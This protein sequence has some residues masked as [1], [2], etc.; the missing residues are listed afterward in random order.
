MLL[1]RGRLA[2]VSARRRRIL[3][4]F[5]A[6]AGV[7]LVHLAIASPMVTL[8]AGGLVMAFTYIKLGLDEFL[9]APLRLNPLSFY[10]FWL[11]VQA[12]L[13]ASYAGYCIFS[14]ETL[15]LGPWAVAP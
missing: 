3:F 11:A 8:V 2:P 12:G 6:V 4:H 9:A 13:S 14:G 10:F 5:T 1:D 15:Q 7:W